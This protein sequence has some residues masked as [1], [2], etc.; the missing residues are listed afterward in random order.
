MSNSIKKL[1]PLKVVALVDEAGAEPVVDEELPVVAVAVELPEPEP[2]PAPA[3]EELVVMMLELPV[4]R[5]TERLEEVESWVELEE[6]LEK[7]SWRR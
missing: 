4:P 5:G 7:A 2:E 6:L 1:T 3:V